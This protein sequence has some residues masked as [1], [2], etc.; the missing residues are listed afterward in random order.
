M[1]DTLLEK[2]LKK[3]TG[4]SLVVVMD[5]G[6]SFIGTLEDFDKNTLVLTDV[7]QGSSSEVDWEEV[8]KDIGS[9]IEEKIESKDER[10]GFI[11]W[12]A[13]HLEEVYIRIDHVSRIWPWKFIEKKQPISK[14][15][16]TGPVYRDNHSKPNIT[17]G[18]DIPQGDLRER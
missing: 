15:Y 6:L 10:Y 14:K 11:D 17:A 12:T 3:L 4:G 8:S 2:K 13:V 9:D 7:Y 18:M 5:D 16:K 1:I